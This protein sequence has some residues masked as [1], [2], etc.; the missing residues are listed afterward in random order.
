[1]SNNAGKLD[2][3]LT[4]VSE[5]KCGCVVGINIDKPNE[6]VDS[7]A[8]LLLRPFSRKARKRIRKSF[9]F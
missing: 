5:L 9:S 3:C 4:D 8:D 2:L 6:E 1:M 7:F